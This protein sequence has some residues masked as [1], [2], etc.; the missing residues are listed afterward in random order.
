MHPS[1][2]FRLGAY[3]YCGVSKG[4]PI[5][6]VKAPCL[7]ILDYGGRVKVRVKNTLAYWI[8]NYSVK[9][10]SDA[11]YAECRVLLIDKPN[12]IKLSVIVMN[13]IRLY[14]GA[15]KGRS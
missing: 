11:H 13:V 5:I 1:L 14:V 6:Q 10:L 7:Q 8:T 4:D 12:V 2:T 9:T 15:L 3:P